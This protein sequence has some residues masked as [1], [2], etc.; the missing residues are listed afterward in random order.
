M[1]VAICGH[2]AFGKNLLNGQTIKTKILSQE[3][4][5]HFSQK[6][7][8]MIDTHGVVNLLLLLPRLI[9]ALLTCENILILPAHRGVKII[10][11]WLKLWNNIFSK[12]LHYVVIGG[13]L[14]LYIEKYSIISY[15]IKSFTGI[16]V[17][18][19]TM[20]N[21]LESQG[22]NNIYL[23]PNCKYL[24]IVK[25]TDLKN[26]YDKPYK[27]CTFS[28]VMKEKGIA[29]AIEVVKNINSILGET[30]YCLDIYGSIDVNQTEWFAEAQS[31]FPEYVSYK[32]CVNFD[33]SVDTI[34]E[35]FAL[36]FPTKFFTE[37][38]PGTIID[39]YAA[40]VPVIASKW[41][42][43]ADIIEDNKTGLCYEFDNIQ[44]LQKILLQVA[45]NPDMIIKKK[46]NCIKSAEKYLPNTVITTIL[47]NL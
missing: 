4:I 35:Y 11:I 25:N 42:S 20:K 24:D 34:K 38:I 7:V 22:F 41:Q 13:W 44:E 37:G 14:P 2:F 8:L 6:S 45:T 10:T 29:D 36:L 23:L 18:T 27:L 26:T 16:Y 12:K 17:E 40:G 21:I 33:K 32:G 19:A 15:A 5:K 46:Y 39:A 47:N 9:Y 28:R 43:Y 3:L 31:Q 30:V 1:K